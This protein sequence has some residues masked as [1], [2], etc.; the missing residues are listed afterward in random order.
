MAETQHT[1]QTPGEG[2]T[3]HEEEHHSHAVSL[4]LLVAVFAALL[5]LTWVTVAVATLDLG[6]FDLPVAMLVA[7]VKGALVVTVFM[8]LWWDSRFNAICLVGALAF[9]ALLIGISGLD[10]GQYKPQKDAYRIDNPPAAI[11]MPES[12]SEEASGSETSGG[13]GDAAAEPEQS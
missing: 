12:A 13:A 7:V 8:H 6:R 1:A 11:E 10:V 3:E 9:V 4:K 5:V 2:G